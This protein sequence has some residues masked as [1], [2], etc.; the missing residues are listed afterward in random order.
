MVGRIV[1]SNLFGNYTSFVDYKYVTS[2]V[3]F[4]CSGKISLS[5]AIK[6]PFCNNKKTTSIEANRFIRRELGDDNVSI[7]KA[8]ISDR[9]QYVDPQVYIDM[10]NVAISELYI[11]PE[12]IASFKGFTVSATDA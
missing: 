7:T 3:A 12:E 6:Y 2:D 5:S 10:N 1:F 11:Y 9:M 4:T 8:E